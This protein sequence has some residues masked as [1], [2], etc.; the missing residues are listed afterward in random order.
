[1]RVPVTANLDKIYSQEGVVTVEDDVIATVM[2]LF[3]L[4][5]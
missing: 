4:I 2:N 5:S 1:M 3:V